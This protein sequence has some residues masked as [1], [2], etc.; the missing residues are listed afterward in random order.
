MSRI[1]CWTRKVIPCTKFCC[2]TY[3][4]RNRILHSAKRDSMRPCLWLTKVRRVVTTPCQMWC[5]N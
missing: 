1:H 2:N 5:Y 4:K 3:D